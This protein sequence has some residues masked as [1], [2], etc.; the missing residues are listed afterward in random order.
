MEGMLSLLVQAQVEELALVQEALQWAL[1][2]YPSP[3]TPLKRKKKGKSEVTEKLEGR[4]GGKGK[5]GKGEEE[6]KKR[7]EAEG[8]RKEKKRKGRKEEEK[9]IS[10]YIILEL[11][12]VTSEK[13]RRTLKLFPLIERKVQQRKEMTFGRKK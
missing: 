5:E 10:S 6:E 11:G 7:R 13:R 9:K 2:S 4:G 12:K 3:Y 8:K 1:R